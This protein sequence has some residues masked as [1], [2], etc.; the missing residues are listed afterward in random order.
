MIASSVT[1]IEGAAPDADRASFDFWQEKVSLA[2]VLS[3]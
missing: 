2:I 3:D 1:T